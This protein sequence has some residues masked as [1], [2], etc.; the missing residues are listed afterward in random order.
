M[1]RY[2]VTLEYKG[3]GFHGFQKQPGLLTVQGALESAILTYSGEEV[4]TAGAGRTD[5]GVHAVGQAVTFDLEGEADPPLAVRGLNGLLPGGV[6]VTGMREVPAGFDPRREALWREYR[7]LVLNRRSPSPLM[8]EFAFHLPGEIDRPLAGKACSLAVGE[9]DFSAFRV[10]AEEASTLREVLVCELGEFDWFPGLLCLRVR[11][12]SFLYRMVRLLA[13]AVLAVGT[14]RMSLAGFEGHL[15]GGS[16]PC[17]EPLPAHGLFLWEVA[18][19]PERLT[20][21]ER[22]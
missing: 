20:L 9:H 16:Q 15:A 12:G 18:Y 2:L 1:P 13:G 14:G 6:A 21:L 22:Y 17:S 19:R 3:T 8:G 4:R 5:A 7:Y 11:A 10:K